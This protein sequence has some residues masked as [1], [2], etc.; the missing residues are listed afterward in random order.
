MKKEEI[1]KKLRIKRK[2]FDYNDIPEEYRGDIE[3]IKVLREVGIRK[4]EKRGYDV[5]TNKFFVYEFIGCREIINFFDDFRSFYDYLEGNIYINSCYYQLDYSKFDILN[6][7]KFLKNKS[8]IKD[9]IDDYCLISNDDINSYMKYEEDKNNIKG[10]I[11]RFVECDTY[12]KFKKVV[13]CCRRSRYSTNLEFFFWQYI[14]YDLKDYNRLRILGEHLWS[15]LSLEMLSSICYLYNNDEILNIFSGTKCEKTITYI[16]NNA[17]N[18]PC[19]NINNEEVKMVERY[20]DKKIHYYIEHNKK[21]GV[22]RYFETFD[23]FLEYCNMDL[24]NVDLRH[25]IKLEYDFSKCNIDETTKLPI[26]YE[27]NLIYNIEKYYKDGYFYVWQ[28]W[29]TKNNEHIKHDL[30]RFRWFFDFVWFLKGDLSN[31]DLLFCDGLINLRNI[32]EINLTNTK[33]TSKVKQKLGIEFERKFNIDEIEINK[34]TEENENKNKMECLQERKRDITI[35]E[36]FCQRGKKNSRLKKEE[37]IYYISDIHLDYK[38]WEIDAKTSEDVEYILN[39]IVNDIVNKSENIILIGGDITGNLEIFKLFVTKMRNE[40]DKKYFKPS[41]IFTLGNHELGEGNGECSYDRL[42]K[43]ESIV[44][45]YGMY[46]LQGNIIFKDSNDNINFITTEEILSLD[47][48]ELRL[49]VREARVILFGG[50]TTS[51]GLTV[52]NNK[53][54]LYLKNIYEKIIKVFYDKKIVVLTHKPINHWID[55]GNSFKFDIEIED[56]KKC[57]KNYIYVSGHTHKN[58]WYDDGE[59]RIYSDNQLGYHSKQVDM[60]YFEVDN[61]YDFFNDYKDGVYKITFEEYKKFLLGKN[62][63]NNLKKEIECIH[64][65]KKN[66]F[67]CFLTENTY[68]DICILNGGQKKIIPVANISQCYSNMDSIINNIK[69][70]LDKY[71]KLQNLIS[72]EIKELGGS[73]NIHGCIID[74]DYY[75]HVFV[76]PFDMKITFYWAE[77]IIDK[78]LYSNPVMLLK[79]KCPKLYGQYK[80][81]KKDKSK[82]LSIIRGNKRGELSISKY[83]YGT[84]MYKISR[85]LRKMQKINSNVLVEWYDIDVDND[86]I[87]N[88]RLLNGM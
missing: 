45:E 17:K 73:G 81:I 21:N 69:K 68:G 82:Q 61:D 16:L 44:K 76:N 7:N 72:K 49:K 87:S 83:H 79:E 34:C 53:N 46:L 36:H 27:K 86:M 18:K 62:I 10:W 24:H 29:H 74:I 20:F 78:K 35:F 50:F 2:K 48:T 14:Y 51:G 71:T 52:I 9:T 38:L 3:I 65:L 67:Y 13:N 54:C 64:M 33:I 19:E 41:V 57:Y 15:E 60:K 39:P 56:I 42:C 75:N 31:S 8:F 22:Y 32:S 55:S 6:C 59:I 85:E 80:E 11:G 25:A 47:M 4:I 70:P 23:S 28:E 66:G 26:Q 40:I 12:D 5:I 58:F 1:I 63:T 84:E 43:Y 77:N 37:K 30:Q 88:T